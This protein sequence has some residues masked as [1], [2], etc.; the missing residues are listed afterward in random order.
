MTG[1]HRFLLHRRPLLK[2]FNHRK[3]YLEDTA[4]ARLALDIDPAVMVLDDA[5]DH[6]QADSGPFAGSLG[7]EKWFEYPLTHPRI[8]ARAGVTHRQADIAAPA[9]AGISS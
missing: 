6:R 1:W 7:G 5:M 8:H 9:K 2:T 4:L 3:K